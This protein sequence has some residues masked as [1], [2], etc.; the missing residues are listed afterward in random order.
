MEQEAK[1]SRPIK[2]EFFVDE[3]ENRFIKQKMEE[4][5]IVNFSQFAREMLIF[6]EVKKIDFDKLK[7]LRLEI[8]RIGVNVNQIAKRVNENGDADSGDVAECLA[9]LQELKE[10]TNRLIKDQLKGGVT[11][12]WF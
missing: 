9:L 7:Q 12:W 11:K 5:G 8:N 1:R 2:K 4:V 6:G 3:Q 10:Q